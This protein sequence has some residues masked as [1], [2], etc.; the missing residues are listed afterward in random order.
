MFRHLGIAST[1]K[2]SQYEYSQSADFSHQ[3]AG[4]VI[5]FVLYGLWMARG[6]LRDVIIKAWRPSQGIDDS[7][8]LMP[9][10]L[11]FF[12]GI[13]SALFV[14]V[15]L[16]RSGI[17]LIVVPVF[18]GIC[19]IYY[20]FITR[21]VA[22]SGVPTARPPLVAPYFAISGMGTSIL[23]AKGLVAMGFSMVWQAEMRLFPMLACANALK[24]AETVRGPKRRLLWGMLLALICA[25]VGSTWVNMHIGYGYGGNNLGS[26]PGFAYNWDYMLSWMH[27]PTEANVRG[28]LFTGIGGTI[29]GLLLLA[30]K[31]WFWWPLHP[32]GFTV[33]VGWLTSEI[34]FP[35][36]VAW[37][38]KLAIVGYGGVRLYQ[39][40]KPFFLGM[41]LGEV[42]VAGVWAVV[43]SITGATGNVITYM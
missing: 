13:A 20:I 21:V 35:A 3:A 4:A 17:P 30:Q 27:N 36:F 25:L 31:R 11:A 2:L 5:V 7:E 32:L 39:L 43:D 23:G 22:A 8:E 38:L 16:W 19:I 29:E 26:Y 18:F 41:I 28:W 15:W 12:G 14:C 42:T 1:E 6:H 24:L 37:I 10:R 33:A 9:Y 34:W 40:F